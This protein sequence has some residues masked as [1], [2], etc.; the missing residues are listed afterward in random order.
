M[1]V[2]QKNGQEKKGSY[3]VSLTPAANIKNPN[4][5]KTKPT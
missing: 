1:N 4:N 2:Q 5:A 3:E